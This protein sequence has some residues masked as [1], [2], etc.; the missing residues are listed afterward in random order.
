MTTGVLAHSPSLALLALE[1]IRAALEYTASRLAQHEHL[2]PGDGHPV[3]IFPG[4]AADKMAV[5]PL[6]G[7]CEKLGYAAYDWGRGVNTGPQGDLEEWIE[8]LCADVLAHQ[9]EHG[10][11]VSLVGWSLGGIYAR[12][13]AKKIPRAVRQVVTLGAPF[14]GS[15]EHTNVG[16]LYRLLSGQAPVVDEAL[17]QRL[18]T[19][20]DVPTT[21]IYSRTDGVVAWQCCVEREAAHLESI[22]VNEASHVGLVWNT[23]VWSILADRLSQPEGRWQPYRG[24]QAHRDPPSLELSAG[25]LP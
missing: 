25:E 24:T 23:R 3:V 14:G 6:R 8:E 17:G 12:E 15:G 13:V 20:P 21:A 11:R 7:F 19:P 1:P 16:W 22:E 10:R 4:L 9:R 5:G 2:P 18:C